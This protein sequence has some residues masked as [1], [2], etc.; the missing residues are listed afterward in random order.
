M[1]L[2]MEDHLETI[3]CTLIRIAKAQ[4]ELLAIALEARKERNSLA[5][6]MKKAFQQPLQ[7]PK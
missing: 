6:Q 4:E 1:S 2:S 3:A 5:D 7:E